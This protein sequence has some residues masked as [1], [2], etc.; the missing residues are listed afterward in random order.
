[1]IFRENSNEADRRLQDKNST[2]HI[3]Q[4]LTISLFHILN[5]CRISKIE[6]I[7]DG[8]LTGPPKK[9]WS[10]FGGVLSFTVVVY[11]SLPVV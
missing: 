4:K 3:R 5:Q 1:M 9:K 11:F 8:K 6:N 2:S 10:F 7:Y